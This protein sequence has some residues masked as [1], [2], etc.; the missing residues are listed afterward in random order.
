MARDGKHV[1]YLVVD[2]WEL[3]APTGK[4]TAERFGFK[5]IGEDLR[6]LGNRHQFPVVTGWQANRAGERV[7]SLTE[8][9]I[10]EDYSVKK[11]SDIMI[12][13]N[14][15]PEEARNNKLRLG[16]LKQRENTGK[17]DEYPIVCDLSRMVIRDYDQADMI[18]G[19]NNKI[20]EVTNE[21][22][23]E[24]PEEQ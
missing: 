5:Q 16:I 15:S 11:T 6:R 9:H 4:H 8:E 22:V 12:T 21:R 13:L 24:V 3:L 14:Q 17:Y 19:L 20:V 10:G 18:L 23:K 1:D 2:Y 7:H